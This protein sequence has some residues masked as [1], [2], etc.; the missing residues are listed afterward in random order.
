MRSTSSSPGAR[1]VGAALGRASRRGSAPSRAPTATATSRPARPAAPPA[2]RPGRRHSRSPAAGMPSPSIA[3]PSITKVPNTRTGEEAAR[4][5]DHDRRLAD[6]L[7]VVEG[8]RHGLVVGLLAPDDLHQLHLV[9]RAEE[10]DADEFLRRAGWP[11]PGR[12]IGRVE[13]LDAKKPPGASIGSA[14]CVT[15]AFSSRFSNT[16]SMMRSQPARLRPSRRSP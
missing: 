14:S 9:H 7:H 15:R 3:A 5:V 11:W 10:M 2:C 16:A 13:V 1:D 8:A 12:V 4:V 6:V